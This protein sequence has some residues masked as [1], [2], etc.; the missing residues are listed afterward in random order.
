MGI[1]IIFWL[2]PCNTKWN[3]LFLPIFTQSQQ[4]KERFHWFSRVL[5][6]SVQCWLLRIFL[7]I[8]WT[9]PIFFFLLLSFCSSVIKLTIVV[10]FSSIQTDVKKLKGCENGFASFE[11]IQY[12]PNSYVAMRSL[13][14]R[15][16]QFNSLYSFYLCNQKSV[17]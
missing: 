9:R 5:E 11:R 12:L 17:K 8:F 15:N 4:Y 6:V 13:L 14:I 1:L 7:D 2:K 3:Y 10:A 16:I